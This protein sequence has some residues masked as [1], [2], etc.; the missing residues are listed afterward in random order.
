MIALHRLNGV[1]IVVNADLIESVESHGAETVL[2]L[3][4][5]NKIL[6]REPVS[7]VI[8]KTVEYKRMVFAEK[9]RSPSC[10]SPS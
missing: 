2:A 10:P 8:Q 9:E 6:V 7:D 3:S 5:G 4:T 1:G